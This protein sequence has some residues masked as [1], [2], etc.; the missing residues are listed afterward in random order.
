MRILLVRFEFLR[1]KFI[2]ETKMLSSTYKEFEDMKVKYTNISLKSKKQS[3]KLV[4][5]QKA[6]KS[7]RGMK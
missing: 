4:V 1:I 3:I 5:W 6:N 7:V 2:K